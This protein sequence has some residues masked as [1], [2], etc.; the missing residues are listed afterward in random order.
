MA[1]LSKSF[2]Y[3]HSL[4]HYLTQEQC[5]V[6]FI[7]KYYAHFTEKDTELWEIYYLTQSHILSEPGVIKVG[8]LYFKAQILLKT[9][10]RQ[11]L[12]TST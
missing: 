5:L 6:Y 3:G 1:L 7:T 9:Q 8:L 2:K 11:S 12:L 4:N 10:A